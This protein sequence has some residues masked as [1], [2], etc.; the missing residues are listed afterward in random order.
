M[1]YTSTAII[2]LVWKDLENFYDF[3][4]FVKVFKS[5]TLLKHPNLTFFLSLGSCIGPWNAC[6]L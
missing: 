3:I 5:Q 2:N 4:S 6:Y 1:A